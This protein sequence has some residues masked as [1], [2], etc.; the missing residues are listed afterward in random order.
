MDLEIVSIVIYTKEV[1]VFLRFDL[2]VSQRYRPH[3]PTIRKPSDQDTKTPTALRYDH[4]SS[5]KHWPSWTRAVLDES[6]AYQ[7]HEGEYRH[8]SNILNKYRLYASW[9]LILYYQNGSL[10]I[11]VLWLL[12]TSQRTSILHFRSRKRALLSPLRK[13]LKSKWKVLV[14]STLIICSEYCW[15]RKM[16]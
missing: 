15:K 12:H 6:A 16:T 13:M 8:Y 3:S 10:C 7:S 4:H 11:I 2:V 5:H 14:R 9:C 1:S